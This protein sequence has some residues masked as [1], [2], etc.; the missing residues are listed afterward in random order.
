MLNTVQFELRTESA[1]QINCLQSNFP[2][3]SARFAKSDNR[4]Y[5]QCL[6]LVLKSNTVYLNYIIQNVLHVVSFSNL[7]FFILKSYH[8]QWSMV[9]YM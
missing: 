9:P 6:T 4:K 2:L 5:W 3:I 8:C 7:N 1:M